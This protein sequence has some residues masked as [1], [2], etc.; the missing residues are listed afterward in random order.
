M[1]TIGLM[2]CNN[3]QNVGAEY[4]LR[5]Y[6]APIGGG[7]LKTAVTA[8]RISEHGSSLPMVEESA[9]EHGERT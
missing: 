4:M 3:D 1:P 2:L 8:T 6:T 7:E 9:D 5:G